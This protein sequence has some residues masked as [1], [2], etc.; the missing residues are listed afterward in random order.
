LT[1]CSIWKKW[2]IITS[3]HRVKYASI[4]IIIICYQLKSLKVNFRH[5]IKIGTP[6]FEKCDWFDPWITQSNLNDQFEHSLKLSLFI[7][8]SYLFVSLVFSSLLFI[9]DAYAC[10]IAFDLSCSNCLMKC[11]SKRRCHLHN[12]KLSLFRLHILTILR[13]IKLLGRFFVVFKHFNLN[14]FCWQI[15][16]WIFWLE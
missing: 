12:K 11:L 10:K 8:C 7:L 9:I 6:L 14:Q 1:C 4:I 3:S 15:E 5:C 16:I 13:E 2:W